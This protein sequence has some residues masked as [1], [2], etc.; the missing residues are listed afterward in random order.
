L[1]AIA[2]D[3]VPIAIGLGLIVSGDLERKSFAV[4]E[5]GTAVQADTGDAGNCEIDC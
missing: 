3:C 4:L 2:D 5:R 1:A